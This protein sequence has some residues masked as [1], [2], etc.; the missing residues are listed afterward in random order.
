MKHISDEIFKK[1]DS[2][3][4]MREIQKY[5]LLAIQEITNADKMLRKLQQEMDGEWDYIAPRRYN[6]LDGKQVSSGEMQLLRHA[7]WLNCSLRFYWYVRAI[8][9]VPFCGAR[10]G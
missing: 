6:N 7:P 5:D 10:I 4:I 1:R 2:H 3:G 8:N 9:T